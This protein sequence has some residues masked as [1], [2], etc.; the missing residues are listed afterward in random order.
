[1]F[2]NLLDEVLMDYYNEEFSIYSTVPEH[3][4]S[5]K[6]RLAMKKIFKR[7]QRNTEC[8]RSKQS[9]TQAAGIDFTERKF[10]MTPKRVLV[11]V[12]IIL[13]ATLAGCSVNY[14]ISHGFRNKVYNDNTELF[15]ID[16]ENC[17]TEIE[18]KYHLSE[19]PDGFEITETLSNPFNLTI[20]YENKQ[21]NQVIL[22]SQ[23]VKSEFNSAHFN[24]EKS[25]L[26]NIDINNYK[27]FLL[28]IQNKNQSDVYLIWD[29]DNY[30]LKISGDLDKNTILDL[31]KSAKV[32]DV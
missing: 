28:E 24:T 13:L 25:K 15:A 5:L 31:A 12:I 2:E 21:T 14:F 18:E 32:L 16:L 23:W 7:Y 29:N 19:L 10:R 17:P 8:L 20:I 26:I 3:K 9:E 6:H 1:M 30:I 4:F 27:G 11:L 22:F